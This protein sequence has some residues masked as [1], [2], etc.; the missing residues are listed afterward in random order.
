MQARWL[1]AAFAVVCLSIPLTAVQAS[2]ERQRISTVDA[3]QERADKQVPRPPVARTPTPFAA[4]DYTGNILASPTFNRPQVG[5]SA[6]S[7]VGTAVG[8]DARTVTVDVTGT[9]TIEV[10]SFSG[11]T[12]LFVY[13]PSFSPAA[14]LTNCVASDD[15]GGVGLLSLVTTTLTA[16]VQYVVVTTTF[17]NGATGA[18]TNRIDGPGTATVGGGAA[19]ANVGITIAAPTGVPVVGAYTYLVTATNAGPDAATGVSATITVGAG[20]TINGTSC[21]TTG[22]G[23]TR[24]W[25]IGDLANGANA[26]C[27]VNVTANGPSCTAI[28][29]SA[30][31]TATSIDPVAANNSSSTS[32]GGTVALPEGG[33]EGGT[34]NPVW[35]EASTNFGTP[36][37]DVADC[38][39]G[40]G[41]AGPRSGSWWVW[42]GGV[43][44]GTETGSVQQSIVIPT[45]TTGLEF[46]SRL[47]TCAAANGTSD[48]MRLTIDGV[49]LWRRD[50]TDPSCGATTYSQNV[51]DVSA[52]AGGGPRVIRF[53]S[54]TIGGASSNLLIDDVSFVAPPVCSGPPPVPG[55]TLTKRVQTSASAANCPT[56]GTSV[57]VAPGTQVYYCY[58]ATN[59]GT[60]TLQTHN[61]TD[62]AFATPI[63]SDLQFTLAGGASSPWLVS[64]PVTVTGPTSS[65]ATWTACSQ[66]GNCTG[67]PAGTT[68]TATVAAGAV[69]AVLLQ[70]VQPV[71]TLNPLALL[72]LGLLL[73]G[74]GALVLRRA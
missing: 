36:I 66:A 71:D 56:A 57:T 7:G 23:G 39:T 14:P 51:V 15:D 26:T 28:P 11:D 38:G 43:T 67:A 52:L 18:Y 31:I 1:K 47:G 60:L 40:G 49:E 46:Y 22:V 50:A 8:Y 34:P 2:T 10:L 41:T 27:T 35:A 68:A 6:L 45:G 21:T 54:T 65:A 64:P 12:M 4:V 63:A 3:A 13:S 58:Q 62:T 72:L 55:L 61:V 74:A 20:A 24:T 19:Q 32:N 29:A 48:F 42:F 30:T 17:G 69:T 37:C 70:G 5:C 59:T 53:E 16:G 44:S 25:A 33:F 73:L 9:Y